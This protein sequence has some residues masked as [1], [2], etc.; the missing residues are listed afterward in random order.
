MTYQMVFNSRS[1]FLQMMHYL[2][3]GIIA[4]D[5]DCNNLQDDLFKLEQWQ[6]QWQMEYYYYYYYYY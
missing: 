1:G 4:S 6:S 5:V 2:V 3:Y